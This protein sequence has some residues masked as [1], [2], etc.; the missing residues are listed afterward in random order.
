LTIIS[1]ILFIDMPSLGAVD[2]FRTN[3]VQ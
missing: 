3:F 2:L 1:V